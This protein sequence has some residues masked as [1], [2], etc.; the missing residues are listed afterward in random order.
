M[1]NRRG[2][3][4]QSRSV[5]ACTHLVMRR[6]PDR[7]ILLCYASRRVRA[8]TLL[9]MRRSPDRCILLCYASRSVRACTHLVMRRS[10]DRCILLCYASRRVR[11]CTLLLLAILVGRC[12]QARTLLA[13]SPRHKNADRI[14]MMNKTP[15]IL[16]ILFIL[17]QTNATRRA[18][19][20]AKYPTRRRKRWRTLRFRR[21]Q[22]PLAR[23]SECGKFDFAARRSMN[24]KPTQTPLCS[25]LPTASPNVMVGRPRQNGHE[26]QRLTSEKPA[27]R[28]ANVANR[29][30]RE[31]AERLRRPPDDRLP[32]ET[33]S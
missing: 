3:K 10:P 6:S 27:Y 25:G 7:C 33:T 23:A 21:N 28:V 29:P 18:T 13:G 14:D 9:V 5:R 31:F 8:C 11:A 1:T 22:L 26:K 20:V 24:S 19:N 17:S 12:V 4:T 30:P 15:E 32:S 2:A 16:S